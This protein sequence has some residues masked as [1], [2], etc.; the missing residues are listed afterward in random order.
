[1]L[2]AMGIPPAWALG[3]LRVSLGYDTRPE[4]IDALLDVLPRCVERVRRYGL[5][6]G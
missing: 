3:S 1:V 4:D 5:S 2:L 6:D